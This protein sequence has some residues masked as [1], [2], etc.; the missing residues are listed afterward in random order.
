MKPDFYKFT[1]NVILIIQQIQKTRT[2]DINLKHFYEIENNYLFCLK[3]SGTI[4]TYILI[5]LLKNIK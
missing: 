4:L 5:Q 3:L 1:W 2:D